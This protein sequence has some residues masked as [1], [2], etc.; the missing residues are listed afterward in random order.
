MNR[1]SIKD[2]FAKRKLKQL[3][4]QEEFEVEEANEESSELEAENVEE[5]LPNAPVNTEE[6]SEVDDDNDIEETKE[7][8]HISDSGGVKHEAQSSLSAI[9]RRK[10]LARLKKLKGE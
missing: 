8:D 3:E 7:Q 10:I 1:I 2:I 5:S 9:K 4:S 6:D